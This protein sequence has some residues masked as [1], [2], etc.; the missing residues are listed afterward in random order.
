MLLLTLPSGWVLTAL[1]GSIVSLV[2]VD[3]VGMADA[4]LVSLTCAVAGRWQ[5]FI[6]LPCL[7]RK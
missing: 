1:V 3:L 2:G 7:W 4:F 5:W 6:L